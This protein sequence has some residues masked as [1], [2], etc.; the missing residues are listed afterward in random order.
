MPFVACFRWPLLHSYVAILTLTNS[1]C[2][3]ADAFWLGRVLCANL[4]LK[5]RQS[6]VGVVSLVYQHR[7]LAMQ[8]TVQ[9]GLAT[10]L[11]LRLLG[12]FSLL[13]LS[14][15]WEEMSSY[16]ASLGKYSNSSYNFYSVHINWTL[17]SSW[18]FLLGATVTQGLSVFG[19]RAFKGVNGN[20]MI[21]SVWDPYK[22]RWF[23]YGHMGNTM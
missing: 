3:S 22:S 9:C 21:W 4:K 2:D 1:E 15:L 6:K 13:L 16:I 11:I 7:S 12:S 19:D 10:C 17:V 20:T 18:K 14:S 23:S 8:C 5:Y